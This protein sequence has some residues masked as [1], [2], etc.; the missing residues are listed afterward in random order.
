MSLLIVAP[1]LAAGVVVG[2]IISIFQ[3]VTSIQ[4][5]TLTFVPKIAAMTLVAAALMP[6]IVA[7]LVEFASEMF[8][9]F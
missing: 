7:R 3:S 4:D 8:R 6:W 9:L 1:I 5:Q 2:L